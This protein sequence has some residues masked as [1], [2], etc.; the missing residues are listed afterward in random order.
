[1][2]LVNYT[3]MFADD[4]K[5]LHG[6]LVPYTHDKEGVDY[7]AFTNS[8]YIKSD[9]WDVRLVDEKDMEKDGRYTARKYKTLPHKILP[10]Y[11][12][13]MW[14]D[15]Q[16]YF[17]TDP[18][19]LVEGYLG[20][21]YDVAAHKHIDRECMYQEVE[22][23]LN[24]P[25]SAGP[26]RQDPQLLIK[27][28]EDYRE[29]GYPEMNGLY[30]TG[31]LLRR[32]CDKVR[33]FNEQWWDESINRTTEDQVSFVYLLWKNQEIRM[34]GI[35]YTLCAHQSALGRKKSPY[36]ATMDKFWRDVG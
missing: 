36:V 20:D 12:F 30:E 32:N 15:N 29:D 25:Q 17:N 35:E 5:K 26:S 3:V 13:H 10:D 31:F 7:I 8:P 21:D 14:T 23:C 1:M 19:S 34:N 22:A 4:P 33:K 24:R 2:K 18:V 28:G 6:D 9:F 16:V 11:D 27:Q